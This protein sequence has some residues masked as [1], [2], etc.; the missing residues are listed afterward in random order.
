M[1]L[2][3]IIIITVGI[4]LN[5]Y[6]AVVCFGAVLARI[7][8]SRLVKM[9]IIFC[10]WQV[11]AEIGGQVVVTV[12]AVQRSLEYMRP[13]CAL[14][15]VIIFISLG[16]YMIYKAVKNEP[17]LERLTDI[18]YSQIIFAGCITGIDAAFAGVAFGLMKTPFLPVVL[19]MLVV[20]VVV[21]ISGLQT[22]MRLGYEH[23]TKAYV[24]G[25]VLLF[26]S[27]IEIIYNYMTK[28]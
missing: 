7:E 4:S 10:L 12:P 1:N 25:G 28:W 8:K 24:I 15:A 20:T 9:L 2:I 5:V 16:L 22:G 27:A 14:L 13:F 19:C 21:V 3:E 18:K 11:L 6:S 26:L 17:I 23:K